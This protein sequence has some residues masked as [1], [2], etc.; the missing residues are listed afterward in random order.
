[1]SKLEV[2]SEDYMKRLLTDYLKENEYK[3]K[4]SIKTW[5]NISIDDDNDED[6]EN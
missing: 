1:M 4:Y 6:L 3:V 2:K 5:L